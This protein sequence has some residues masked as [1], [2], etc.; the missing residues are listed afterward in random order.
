M[1]TVSPQSS[2]APCALPLHP[3]SSA[4]YLQMIETGALGSS[5]RVALIDGIIIDTSPAGPK[6][7]RVL[8]RVTTLFAPLL[9][10][11]ELD[12]Q[13]TLNAQEGQVF[14]S[15]FALLRFRDD[16]YKEVP[17]QPDDVLLVIVVPSSSLQRDRDVKLP[18][19]A[20]AGIREY[21]IADL[22][23]ELMLV[24]REPTGRAYGKTSE[25][26][27]D[28]ALSPLAFDDMLLRVG[29]VFD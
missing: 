26:R 3:F 16:E 19:C 24:H 15:D 13:G 9:P 12:A 8:R 2:D 18:I 4:D 22:Q 28:D 11:C 29:E 14:D 1:S 10:S 6:H 20:E 25:H 17:P 27:S 7:Q 23:R 21:W 5:D